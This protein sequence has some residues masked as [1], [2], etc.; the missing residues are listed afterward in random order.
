[1]LITFIES[2]GT[3]LRGFRVQGFRKL[4]SLMCHTHVV[5]VAVVLYSD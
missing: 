5:I 3:G 1:M 2:K 4:R